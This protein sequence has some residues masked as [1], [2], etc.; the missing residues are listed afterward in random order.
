MK[1]LESYPSILHRILVL[2]LDDYDVSDADG[3]LV[4]DEGLVIRSSSCYFICPSATK[5]IILNIHLQ[6]GR[7]A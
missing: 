2:V 6:R 7:Q 1:T 3:F 5:I 4:E